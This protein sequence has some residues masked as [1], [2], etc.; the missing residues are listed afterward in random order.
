M[1]RGLAFVLAGALAVA[2]CGGGATPTPEPSPSVTPAPTDI[3]AQSPSPSDAAS[4][5][6]DASAAPSA[7]VGG[8]TYTV[9]K[10]DTMWAISQKLGVALDKLI[11]ANPTVDPTKMRI[12]S[13]LVIPPK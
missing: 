11:A 12:G 3:Y 6:P 10:N 9:K 5:A 2:A 7:P 4:T 8:K 1:R 13:V